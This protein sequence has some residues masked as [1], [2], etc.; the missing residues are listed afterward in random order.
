MG[1]PSMARA[2]DGE[3]ALGPAV[4]PAWGRVFGGVAGGLA[5]RVGGSARKRLALTLAG[6]AQR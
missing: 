3:G 1:L 2:A 5:G 4:A 6:S